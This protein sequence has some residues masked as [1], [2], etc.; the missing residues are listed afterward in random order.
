MLQ[1]SPINGHRGTDQ[2]MM[3]I[4]KHVKAH[5]EQFKILAQKRNTDAAMQDRALEIVRNFIIERKLI[6]FGGLGIDLALRV[7]GGRIYADEELPDYDCLS[8]NSVED[9]YDLADILHKNGFWN[10]SAIRAIHVQT[11]RVRTDFISVA[12]VGYAPKDVY[13]SLP[14]IVWNGM[15]VIH[16]NYQR[17]DMHLSFCYPYDGAPRESVFHRWKKDL[18]RFNEVEKYYPINSR[19][20][21]NDQSLPQLVKVSAQLPPVG[22]VGKP[23]IAKFAIHGF[24][25]YGLLRDALAEFIET[26]GVK[27]IQVTAPITHVVIDMDAAEGPKIEFEMPVMAPAALQ[28]VSPFIPE[29]IAEMKKINDGKVT[30]Y[31]PYMDVA[32]PIAVFERKGATPIQFYSTANRLMA[33]AG[34]EAKT[35]DGGRMPVKIVTAQALLLFFLLGAHRAESKEAKDLMTNFY[36]WTLEIINTA[37]KIVTSIGIKA[38][39]DT[40][41]ML[42]KKFINC[43]PFFLT[44]RVIGTVNHDPSYLTRIAK[45][46]KDVTAR[47]ANDTPPYPLTKDIMKL[48][49]NLPMDYFP[50]KKNAIRPKFDLSSPQFQ[51]SGQKR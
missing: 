2:K 51:R 45:V 35:L 19:N 38:S 7:K 25:A 50:S 21:I 47:D 42:V 5:E 6:V 22:K 34:V 40:A 30:T 31:D 3:A 1:Q 27:N 18:K 33:I 49:D 36:L 24:A 46:M 15:R 20:T 12:D 14:F 39:G 41:S 4:E 26:T 32:P 37:T 28:V 13:E 43:T 29:L 17:L 11:M 48:L 44:A 10:I 9:A 23:I 16:P 8:P